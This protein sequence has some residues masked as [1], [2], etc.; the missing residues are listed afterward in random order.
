MLTRQKN[1]GAHFINSH[2]GKSVLEGIREGIIVK[3]P[4]ESE[5]NLIGEY[6][7][8]GRWLD[9]RGLGRAY[10]PCG[11]K[12]HTFLCFCR[13]GGRDLAKTDFTSIRD[14]QCSSEVDRSSIW[15]LLGNSV[16]EVDDTIRQLMRTGEF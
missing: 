12:D 11:K 4:L 3:A 14:A 8:A 7:F 9:G 15:A 16:D 13:G 1:E 10:H 2:Q 6:E 5:V